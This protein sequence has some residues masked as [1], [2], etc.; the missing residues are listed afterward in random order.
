MHAK[1]IKEIESRRFIVTHV[2]D[3]RQSLVT[4]DYIKPPASY[5]LPPTSYLCF[6]YL[7]SFQVLLY[8]DGLNRCLFFF[9]Q[10]PRPAWEAASIQ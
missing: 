4:V 5:F 3:K 1:A 8:T 10:I 7:C 2:Q 6:S 9:T